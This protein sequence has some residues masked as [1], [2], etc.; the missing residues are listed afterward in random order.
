LQVGVLDVKLAKTT[1]KHNTPLLNAILPVLAV[2]MPVVQRGAYSVVCP[3]WCVQLGASNAG[4]Q[5]REEREAKEEE[6]T[7]N[8]RPPSVYILLKSES[9]GLKEKLRRE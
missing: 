7:R 8:S 1:E 9:E 3:T 2:R 5:M 6:A 4:S